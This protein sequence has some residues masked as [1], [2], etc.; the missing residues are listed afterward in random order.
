MEKE[1]TRLE[2]QK[3]HPHRIN[4]F[5]NDEYG[6]AIHEDIIVKYRLLKGK[7]ISEAD[8]E[9]LLLADE[10]KELNIMVFATWRLVPA[11]KWK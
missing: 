1:I 10:K 9:E 3:K 6:F 8:I 2:R 4:V 5:L 11:Q 7:K